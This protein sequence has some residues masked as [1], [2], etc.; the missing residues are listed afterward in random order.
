M[1]LE[2]FINNVL[3]D[4]PKRIAVALSFSVNKIAEA[5]RPS[6][7]FS[8]QFKLPKTQNN[9]N[10]LEVADSLNSNTNIPYQKLPCRLIQNGRELISDGFAVLEKSQENYEIVVYGG[11]LDFFEQIKDKKLSDLDFSDLNHVW[12]LANVIASRLSNDGYIYPIIDWNADGAYMNNTEA[13]VDVRTMLPGVF[14]H[15]ILTRIISTAGFNKT[16][17]LLTD[18]KYLS[19]VIPVVSMKP[20]EDISTSLYVKVDTTNFTFLSS[21]TNYVTHGVDAANIYNDDLN[22]WI[23]EYLNFQAPDFIDNNG[24][25]QTGESVSGNM[26]RY[27]VQSAGV[28]TVKITAYGYTAFVN[29]AASQYWPGQDVGKAIIRVLRITNNGFVILMAEDTYENTP[30][31]NVSGNFSVGDRIVII[32]QFIGKHQSVPPPLPS[33]QVGCTGID[34]VEIFAKIDYVYFGNVFPIANNLPDM[35]QTQFVKF[36]AQKYGVIFQTNSFTK[37]IEFKRFKGI[38]DNIPIAKDWSSKLHIN[39]KINPPE[40][41]YHSDFAQINTLQWDNDLALGVLEDTGTGTINVSDETLPKE[42]VLVKLPFSATE[43]V[44]RLIDRDVPII[45]MLEYGASK[46]SPKPRCLIIKKGNFSLIYHDGTT[47][48]TVTTDIPLCYF[49]LD[50]EAFGLGFDKSLIADNYTEFSFFLDKYK[51]VTAEYLLDENDIYELDFFIPI[52]DNYFK[53]YFFISKV[54][55]FVAG[56]PTKVELI[57][58]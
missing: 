15:T 39:E 11:N 46:N 51:K 7:S 48:T 17:V 4:L 28:Y 58:M 32:K 9:I 42:K 45:K 43:M 21:I 44:K 5:I 29:S 12:N 47:S 35:L 40:I 24:V 38:Y 6:G 10:V 25:Q 36:V 22:S 1:A 57:K 33:T 34:F 19:E 56:K 3:C 26:Y 30:V 37:T 20:T 49:Q 13:K 50:T 53:H 14:E 52:Y 31:I 54:S 16:G 55:N 27:L 41:Q 18:S 23:K 8:N 2:L